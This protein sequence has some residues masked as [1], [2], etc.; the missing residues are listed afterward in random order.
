M[1]TVI[2][3][4][5][6]ALGITVLVTAGVFGAAL[7]AGSATLP[8]I[9]IAVAAGLISL[10]TAGLGPA[11]SVA[12]AKCPTTTGTTSTRAVGL[13]IPQPR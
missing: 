12:T 4:A 3:T 1:E 8:A 5:R 9:G 6:V 7:L 11:T 10:S 2:R 13:H